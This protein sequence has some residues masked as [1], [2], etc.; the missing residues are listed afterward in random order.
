ML[1]LPGPAL[2]LPQNSKD[3]FLLACGLMSDGERHLCSPGGINPKASD[4]CG[5]SSLCFSDLVLAD[6]AV[7]LERFL[8]L[9]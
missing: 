5:W 8:L 4:V 2:T 6:R 7:F 9:L 1:V 3:Y